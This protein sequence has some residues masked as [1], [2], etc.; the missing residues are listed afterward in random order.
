[1]SKGNFY[2]LQDIL[3]KGYD[4][5]VLRLAILSSHYRSQMNFTWAS[6]DQAKENLRRISDWK[7]NL[8]NIPDTSV[9]VGPLQIEQY[10]KRFEGAMDDDLNTPLALSVLYELITETNRKISEKALNAKEAK[11]LLDFWERINKV[12][13]IDSEEESS[14]PEELEKLA[15]ERKAARENK[16]FQKSDELRKRISELGYTIEDREENNFVIKKN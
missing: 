12:L 7:N 6:M 16:D 5:M 4:P 11:K 2:T 14:L 9:V 1:K 15:K 3:D 10:Q 13:G 8:R